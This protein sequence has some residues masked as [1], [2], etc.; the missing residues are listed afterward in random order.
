[1]FAWID[2]N[3][4]AELRQG[5]DYVLVSYYETAC[6]T[7]DPWDEV[8]T[9]LAQRFPNSFVGFGETGTEDEN[10]PLAD[11]KTILNRYYSLVPPIEPQKYIGGYFWWYFSEDMVPMTLPLWAELDKYSTLWNTLY[12]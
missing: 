5:I 4:E 10:A 9:K 2:A 1:M 8:F 7:H 3:V 11:K 12:P 6:P